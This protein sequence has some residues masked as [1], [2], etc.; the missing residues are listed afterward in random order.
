MQEPLG[1]AKAL[2]INKGLRCTLL[3][4]NLEADVVACIKDSGLPAAMLW[5]SMLG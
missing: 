4:T 5:A 3:Q 2:W 1:R